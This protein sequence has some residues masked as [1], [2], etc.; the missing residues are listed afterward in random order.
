MSDDFLTHFNR[1]LYG[2][3]WSLRRGNYEVIAKVFNTGSL[4]LKILK[5]FP[6]SW[7]GHP[8]MKSNDNQINGVNQ[9]SSGVYHC[10]NGGN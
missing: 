9:L 2:L 5:K 6:P 3:E 4:S 1:Q 7:S 8:V 10:T